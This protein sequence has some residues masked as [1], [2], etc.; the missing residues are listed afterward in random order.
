MGPRHGQEDAQPGAT[1]A[2]ACIRYCH[3]CDRAVRPN[4]GTHYRVRN[5]D[6]YLCQAC[7]RECIE[8]WLWENLE[9]HRGAEGGR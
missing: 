2:M 1:V 9:K 8:A 7:R 5:T 6:V 3:Y 4:G